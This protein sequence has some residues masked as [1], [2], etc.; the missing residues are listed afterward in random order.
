M[1][2]REERNMHYEEYNLEGG[3]DKLLVEDLNKFL[4]HHDIDKAH[5]LKRKKLQIIKFQLHEETWNN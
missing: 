5:K 1:K 4:D 3:L 2:K